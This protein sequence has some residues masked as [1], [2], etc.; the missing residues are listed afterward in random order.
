MTISSNKGG[1]TSVNDIQKKRN[2]TKLFLK[3]NP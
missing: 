1:I 2:R 3:N